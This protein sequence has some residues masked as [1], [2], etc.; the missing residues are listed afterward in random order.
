MAASPPADQTPP[1]TDATALSARDLEKEAGLRRAKLVATALLVC[2]IT[3]MIAAKLLEHRHPA[4]GF[5]A[6]FAEA[7]TI[8]GLADWYAVVALFKHP[9][10]LPIPHT[11]I[12]QKNQARIADSLG[13]FVE[14]NFLAPGPVGTKLREVD[15]AA[16]IAAW[17][18]DPAKSASLSRFAVNLLPNAIAGMD[19]SRMKE[20]LAERLTDQVNALKLGPLAAQLLGAVTADRRHQRLLDELIGAVERILNDPAT[21]EGIREK[22]RK[23]LPTL[24][25]LF[26]ADAYL[27][28]RILRS[29]STFL[30]EVKQDPDHALRQEFDRF[31]QSF[32][33][34][35]RE[36]PDY[37]ARAEQFKHDVL[38]RQELRDVAQALWR[39]II[40][41]VEKDVASPQS[42]IEAQMTAIL[43][44]I[45]AKLASDPR[46]KAE[47]NE[48]F[49]VA[50]STL[51][52]Q[53]KSGAS[54]FIADQ[55]KAWNMQQLIRLIELNIGRDL[56][57]IRLNGTLIGGL[58]GLV[59]HT[60]EVLLRAS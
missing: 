49:V 51:V 57:Y 35:L 23:E 47:M 41:Y 58:A 36:S 44:E 39:N 37:E 30:D 17:L 50:L 7:A 5:I 27:L 43:T 38:G 28:S 14:T 3:V 13:K 1:A 15:F 59:L 31:V 42:R 54:R 2:S 25:N 16:L 12:I 4:F 8:G 19:Q 21:V 34:G 56:Q 40:A 18:A 53:Q 20:F 33:V 10:G 22:I 52:D 6:A 46:M 26:K 32:I 29:T 9:M 11:A 48:G 60:I 45:G 55:V 24:F